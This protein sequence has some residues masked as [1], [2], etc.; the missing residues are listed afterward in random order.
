[1]PQMAR[2]LSFIEEF[3]YEVQHR[4]GRQ[5]GNADGLSRQPESRDIEIDEVAM[6]PR[7]ISIPK[8]Y[9]YIQG[10]IEPTNLA[11]INADGTTDRV[12]HC[13]SSE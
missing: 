12:R 9:K 3:D 6:T 11:G 5:H 2:W 8:T 13:L 4:A 1:M 10:P 7:R